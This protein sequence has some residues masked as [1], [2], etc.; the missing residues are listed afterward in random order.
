MPAALLD[1]IKEKIEQASDL[2][3]RLVLLVA[4]SGSGKTSILRE[5]ARSL[6]IPLM[7]VN[8]G[9]S[10]RMLDLT[11]RQRALNVAGLLQDLLEELKSEVVLLDNVEIL[12]DISL[13]QDPLKLL[14]HISRNKTIVAGWNGEIKGSSLVYASPEHPE[15]RRYPVKE[16]LIVQM[17]ENM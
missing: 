3:Y 16:L 11:T 12:F 10:R 1:H 9:L 17:A 7:N 14:Q 2:Y 5:T 13:K 15:Y 6:R 8:L 4:L